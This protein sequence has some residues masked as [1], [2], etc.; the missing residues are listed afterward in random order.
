N[1]SEDVITLA[2]PE[3]LKYED[4]RITL[5]DNLGR[6]IK[7]EMIAGNELKIS[8]L[9]NGIYLLVADVKQNRYAI[10]FVKK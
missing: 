8:N 9:K 2:L 1:P 5:F 6:M 3:E 7:Q 10:R 4:V